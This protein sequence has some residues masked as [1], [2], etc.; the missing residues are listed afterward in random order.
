MKK[1]IIGNTKGYIITKEEMDNKLKELIPELE[2]KQII[3][4]DDSNGLIRISYLNKE[5]KLMEKI[6]EYA[7]K[8]TD[9]KTKDMYLNLDKFKNIFNLEGEE[10]SIS[11]RAKKDKNTF[12]HIGSQLVEFYKDAGKEIFYVIEKQDPWNELIISEI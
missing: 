12:T 11:I 7:V 6:N 5:I 9:V 8:T 4:V 3:S 1:A 2:D 10:F